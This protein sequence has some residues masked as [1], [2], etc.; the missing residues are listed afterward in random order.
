M[1][2]NQTPNHQMNGKPA[3]MSDG[4]WQKLHKLAAK[5]YLNHADEIR[6]KRVHQERTL[7]G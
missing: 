3:G 6:E 4:A 2:E 1:A 5:I 7:T